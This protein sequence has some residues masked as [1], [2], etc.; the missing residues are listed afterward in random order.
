MLE[1]LYLCNRFDTKIGIFL[2]LY[3]FFMIVTVEWMEK[4]FRFFDDEY[5]GGKL[6]TPE[7]GVTGPRPG[8]GRWRIRELPD[9]DVQ[10]FMILKFPCP[11]I[12]I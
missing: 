5:F 1:K 3:T 8:S 4:W 6:P 7:L 12:M 10:N 9:G 2:Y 11:P